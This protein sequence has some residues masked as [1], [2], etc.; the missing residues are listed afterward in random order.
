MLKDLRLS[1]EAAKATGAATP[2]GAHA[3]EIYAAYDAAG[4][5]GAD[6]SGIIHHLRELAARR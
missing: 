1:Q 4:H 5:G 2:M 6:F 3:E